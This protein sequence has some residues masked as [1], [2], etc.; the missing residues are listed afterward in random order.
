MYG[1]TAAAAAAPAAAVVP[2]AGRHAYGYSD[3][4]HRDCKRL[5][6]IH[7][8]SLFFYRAA[9]RLD[10]RRSAHQSDSL[11]GRSQQALNGT[12]QAA[13][14]GRGTVLV[15]EREWMDALGI[16]LPRRA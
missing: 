11:F 6:A 5:G 9:I 12:S 7:L 2:A 8:I 10:Q 1:R 15:D 13:N 14:A 16:A 3:A 4:R